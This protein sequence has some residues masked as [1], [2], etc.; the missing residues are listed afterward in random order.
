VNGWSQPYG[1]FSARAATVRSEWSSYPY[2]R[3]GGTGGEG[4]FPMDYA[5]LVLNRNSS[6]YN[7]GAY[8]GAFP[9]LMNA[10][11]GSIYHLGYPAEGMWTNGCSGG[12]CRPWHCRAGV[13]RYDLYSYGKWDEG[14]SCYDTGGSSG[15]P[16][17]EYW[18]G[19]WTVAS[20]QSHM[21]VV[22]FDSNGGRYGY[23]FFGPYLDGT[24]GSLFDYARSL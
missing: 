14:M 20:V 19:Q 10:P 21:G 4:Y 18:N 9:F 6:G 11:R 16:W 1:S 8:V 7:A 15:G 23:S 5:F 17:F 13:Q 12:Y 3:A 24:T 22:H 2:N